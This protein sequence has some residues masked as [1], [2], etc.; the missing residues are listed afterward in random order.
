MELAVVLSFFSGWAI[1]S[2]LYAWQEMRRQRRVEAFLEELEQ[3][4]MH[5]HEELAVFKRPDGSTVTGRVAKATPWVLL[6]EY[7]GQARVTGGQLFDGLEPVR[8]VSHNTFK[9]WAAQRG[10][11]NITRVAYVR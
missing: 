3:A 9:P 4:P 10:I 6:V 8:L 1:R 2:A 5:R 7:P 11:D